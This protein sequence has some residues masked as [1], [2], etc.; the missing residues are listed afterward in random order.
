MYDFNDPDV[1]HRVA[2]GLR[3]RQQQLRPRPLPAPGLARPGRGRRRLRDQGQLRQARRA[4]G[5]RLGRRRHDRQ[6]R[7]GA[8][9]DRAPGRL[10]H[11]Q[12]PRAFPTSSSRPVSFATH[13]G[14]EVNEPWANPN[15]SRS[16]AFSWGIPITHTGVEASYAFGTTASLMLGHRQR[17][18]QRR[19]L[20]RRQSRGSCSSARSRRS[21]S[22]RSSSTASTARS[23]PITATS[24]RGV[25]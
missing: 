6:R 17:L 12:L 14:A 11:L 9:L 4:H 7:R 1:Q 20:E 22:S 18:G 2:P 24:K 16:L 21:S 13:I 10:H 23:N 25:G 3:S 5:G 19:R 8:E 15:I